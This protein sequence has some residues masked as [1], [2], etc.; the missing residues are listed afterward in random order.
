MTNPY[1][2]PRAKLQDLTYQPLPTPLKQLYYLMGLAFACSF[3]AT[4]IGIA[5]LLKNAAW[6]FLLP[7]LEQAILFALIAAMYGL[8]FGFY[9]FLVFRPL[10]LRKRSTS[11]WWLLAVVALI[12]MWLG[13]SVLPA[14]T[15]QDESSWLEIILGSLEIAF[16][17]VGGLLAAR[18]LALEYL[19]T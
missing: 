7:L 19:T 11:K 3:I 2:V 5:F 4:T 6:V 13:F 18:P 16:L 8:L 15:Q 14:S 10:H 1:K 17:L 12:M 9:Y